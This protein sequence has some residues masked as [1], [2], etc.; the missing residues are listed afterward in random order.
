MDD[1][2]EGQGAGARVVLFGATGMVGAG[3][4]RAC[5]EDP[6]VASVVVLGR[7]TCGVTHPKV[8]EIIHDDFFD[9]AGLEAQLSGLDACLF[10]LGVSAAGMSEETY[11]RI[12]HDLTLAAARF[13]L[14]HN[15]A[16]RFCFVS[17]AGTDPS[18]RSRFMWA[19]VKGRTENA[20]LALGFQEAYMF[21]PGY[22]QPVDG[23]RSSTPFYR[24]AYGL[25]GFLYPALERLFP[26]S[27]TTTR[28]VGRALV[29]VGV[30]GH[31]KPV[32]GIEEIN[33]IAEA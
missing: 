26:R 18:G 9:Y 1:A 22:I 31:G 32:V 7:R 16:I 27:M 20:L 6:R 12:T 15:P 33:R 8:H 17:G 29:E 23:A 10:C 2:A 25:T 14:A 21:R 13:L 4:L 11:T 30:E 28:A 3:A 19:R 5:L 24:A